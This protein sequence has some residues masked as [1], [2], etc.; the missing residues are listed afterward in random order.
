MGKI[1]IG[2]FER[3]DVQVKTKRPYKSKTILISLPEPVYQALDDYCKRT[4]DTKTGIVKGLIVK[5]LRES[6]Y[7]IF[8]IKIQ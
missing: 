4:F 5:F 7:N 1:Y 8:G 6:G 3:G 2:G